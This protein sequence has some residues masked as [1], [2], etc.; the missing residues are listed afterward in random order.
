MA[1]RRWDA[2]APAVCFRWPV[3]ARHGQPSRGRS[4]RVGSVTEF[5]EKLEAI[6]ARNSES[7]RVQVERDRR[8]QELA[9]WLRAHGA[10]YKTAVGG[11]S[12][13]TSYEYQRV[14][15][16]HVREARHSLSVGA[17]V[18][19]PR[20]VPLSEDCVRVLGEFKA[21]MDRASWPGS[22][23]VRMTG[24]ESALYA[25][26][27]TWWDRARWSKVG[28]S[29]GRLLQ[30]SLLARYS[31]RPVR[32]LTVVADRDGLSDSCTILESGVYWGAEPSASHLATRLA[33]IAA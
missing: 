27:E 31:L 2:A 29:A 24:C 18:V 12:R 30:R 26:Y 19:F 4:D 21:A 17:S 10:T 25:E 1:F 23:W 15:A 32:S 9:A 7:E 14:R 13:S 28:D 11:T 16:D 20:A 5:S 33:E 3:S 8:D 6:R 22:S